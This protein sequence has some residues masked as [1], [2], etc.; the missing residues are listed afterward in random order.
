MS[1]DIHRNI[2]ESADKIRVKTKMKRGTETRNED[3]HEILVKGD[4]PEDVV[5]KV[6]ETVR[7][8][9]ETAEDVRAIQPGS[10]FQESFLP[11]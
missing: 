7:R 11:V 8:M 10:V 2:T 6:N 9:R 3:Q 4:E 5:Q 1:E